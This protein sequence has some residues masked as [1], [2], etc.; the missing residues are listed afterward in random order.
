MTAE[1]VGLYTRVFA[2]AGG[3]AEGNSIG[4]L[5][6]E[7]IEATAEI[8]RQGY[9]TVDGGRVLACIF[10]SR[11]WLGEIANAFILSP[12]AVATEHHGQGL[13]SVLIRHGLEALAGQG[14][15]LVITYGDPAYYGRFGFQ[16]VSETELPAPQPLSQPEGW[17][18]QRLD[19]GAL[20]PVPGPSRCVAA[21]NK[22]EYW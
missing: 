21:L 9:V 5:V 16:Q 10:F 22:P 3:D 6:T 19:G 20:A 7:M 8:D 14:V 12:V 1:V 13:G 2:D 18:A 4:E 15:E 17:Q 11:F